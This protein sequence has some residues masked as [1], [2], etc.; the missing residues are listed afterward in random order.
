RLEARLGDLEASR[1]VSLQ[2]GAA[3]AISLRLEPGKGTLFIQAPEEAKGSRV[4]IDGI[5]VGAFDTGMYRD[6]PAGQHRFE[7][8][9]DFISCDMQVKVNPRITVSANAGIKRF[10]SLSLS[11]PG[12]LHDATLTVDGNAVARTGSVLRVEAGEHALQLKHPAIQPVAE[13]QAF[14]FGTTVSWSPRLTYR[15]GSLTIRACPPDAE[16]VLSTADPA[17]S[18]LQ[19]IGSEIVYDGLV[20]GQRT[21]IIR[22]PYFREEQILTATVTEGRSTLVDYP[23]AAELGRLAPDEPIAG[24]FPVSYADANGNRIG[25]QNPSPL[26]SPG[27]YELRFEFGRS[28][29]SGLSLPFEVSP[30]LTTLVPVSLVARLAD[31]ESRAAGKRIKIKAGWASLGLA[32]AGVAGAGL[33]YW[34][35][36]TAMADYDSAATS[37]AAADARA[38]AELMGSLMFASIGA[39]GLGLAASPVLLFAGPDP[40]EL[41]R[42]ANELTE[43][44]KAYK[45][46]RR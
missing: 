35:G 1:E 31:V 23:T 3:E 40:Q 27:M 34:L 46:A 4:F 9:G 19:T 7:I 24:R 28:G 41:D 20:V 45:E 2:A 15:T 36:N 42:Q 5:D 18:R 12:Y 25:L 26:L 44:I 6:V 32:A 10:A 8:R 39:G 21:F 14:A 30:G 13:K 33:S 37:A 17:G 16:V 43:L 11:L 22:S 29:K 38:R